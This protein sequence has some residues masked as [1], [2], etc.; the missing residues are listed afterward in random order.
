[1]RTV[2]SGVA[3]ALAAA[4]AKGI[5]HRDVRPANVLREERTRRVVLT[6]FG[7]AAFLESGGESATRLTTVG[8]RIGDPRYMSPE[9]LDGEQLTEQADIYSLGVLGYELLTGEGPYAAATR[10]ASLVAHLHGTPRPLRDLRADVDPVLANVLERCLVR[11]PEQRPRAADISAALA[12]G[13]ISGTPGGASAPRGPLSAFVGE[14]RRRRVWRVG[15]TYAVIAGAFLQVL[16]PLTVGL[17]LT[18]AVQR[19]IIVMVLAGFPVALAL[20]WAFDVREGRVLRAAAH[21]LPQHSALSRLLPWLGLALSA[22][23]AVLAGWLFLSR[24]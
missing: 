19:T 1:V 18:L 8:H 15:A 2:I 24:N 12:R 22:A 10:A 4:H 17:G 6:D 23:L 21:E 7:I 13:A 3:D 5:I 16:E 9:H 14:L 20:A 11:N